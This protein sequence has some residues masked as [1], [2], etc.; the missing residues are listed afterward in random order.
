MLRALK[1][2]RQELNPEYQDFIPPPQLP[3]SARLAM[4]RFGRLA[5]PALSFRCV[6][7]ASWRPA[8][9]EFFELVATRHIRLERISRGA[10]SSV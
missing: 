6:T 5:S 8:A 4:L 7:S 2:L 1:T 9:R 10:R 3:A